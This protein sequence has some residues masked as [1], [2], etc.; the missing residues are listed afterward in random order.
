MGVGS[1]ELSLEFDRLADGEAEGVQCRDNEPKMNPLSTE[2]SGVLAGLLMGLELREPLRLLGLLPLPLPPLRVL[3]R[4]N[5]GL[6]PSILSWTHGGV[7]E[8]EA[9]VSGRRVRVVP[10]RK[11]A[12]LCECCVSTV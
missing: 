7:P 12:A 5:S 3:M 1:S 4:R 8:G 6:L 11:R 9:R 2:G 10:S